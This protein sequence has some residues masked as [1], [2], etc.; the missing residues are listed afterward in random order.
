MKTNEL[1][2]GAAVHISEMA[3]KQAE[4]ATRDGIVTRIRQN[5]ALGDGPR[6]I[7]VQIH[8]DRE[9]MVWEAHVQPGWMEP[10]PFTIQE[11][12]A[13]R[14]GEWQDIDAADALIRLYASWAV[15][16][17]I[18]MLQSGLQLHTPFAQY[19]ALNVMGGTQS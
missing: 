18:P 4:V 17:V 16:E 9:V 6:L 5:P 3:Q 12:R 2:T 15:R 13:E 11:R 10:L 8:N 7:Y 1:K 19:R 14:G